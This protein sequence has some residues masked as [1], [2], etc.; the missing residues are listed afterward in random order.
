MGKDPTDEDALAASTAILAAVSAATFASNGQPNPQESNEA[1]REFGTVAYE[2][3]L[4]EGECQCVERTG[5]KLQALDNFVHVWVRDARS[6]RH[7]LESSVP[8][9]SLRVASSIP[10][11]ELRDLVQKRFSLVSSYRKQEDGD[12]QL[13]FDDQT[14]EDEETFSAYLSG[15]NDKPE[16]NRPTNHRQPSWPKPFAGILWV[17]PWRPSRK[18]PL[19]W[20]DGDNSKARQEAHTGND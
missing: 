16:H 14:L 20:G 9:F 10:V 2:R 6:F 11:S 12:L 1:K 13:C 7:G 15:R 8:Y 18:H 5:R 19:Q 3:V 17:L 4:A